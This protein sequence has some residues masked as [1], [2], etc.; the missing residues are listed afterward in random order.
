MLTTNEIGILIYI[1]KHC[2]RVKEKT[3]SL[4]KDEFMKNNDT[5]DIVIFNI[6]QIGELAKKLSSTFVKKYN[7]VPWKKIKGMRDRIGHGYETISLDAIWLTATEDIDPL[8]QYCKY[9]LNSNK[10]E[11][12]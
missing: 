12:L 6:F 1:I 5:Q 4:T 9:I 10:T 8:E 11:M 3:H 2:K 7:G